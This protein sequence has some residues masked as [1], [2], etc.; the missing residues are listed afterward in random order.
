VRGEQLTCLR[1][2]RDEV[3]TKMLDLYREGDQ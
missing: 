2:L 1:R 3:M